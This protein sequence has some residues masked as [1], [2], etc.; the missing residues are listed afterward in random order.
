[1]SNP[2]IKPSD[3]RFVRPSLVDD[4]G[5]SRFADPDAPADASD[6]AARD[7]ADSG[8][9]FATSSAGSEQPYSPRYVTTAKSR[10]VLL[11]ILGLV[12]LA[13]A[14]VTS[15]SLFTVVGWLFPLCGLGPSM[16]AW[17]LAYGDL[18]EMTAGGRDEEGRG[19]T[20]LAMILGILGTIACAGTVIGLIW[21]GVGLLPGIF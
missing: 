10:G 11:L 1:M 19:L 16:A 6:T 15:F 13:G 3:S 9:V 14:G 8:G 7:E 4:Q 12:G 2:I 5:R 17:I 18:R 20:T 21:L